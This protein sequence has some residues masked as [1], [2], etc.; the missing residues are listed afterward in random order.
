MEH[1]FKPMIR[2]AGAV[3]LGKEITVSQGGLPCLPETDFPNRNSEFVF[4]RALLGTAEHFAP[5]TLKWVRPADLEIIP[6]L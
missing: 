6:S 3:P 1:T 5:E 4:L 2:Q